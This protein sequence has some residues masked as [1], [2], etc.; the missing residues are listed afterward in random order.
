MKG[1][2]GTLDR[3]VLTRMASI[4]G[5]CVASFILLFLVVDGFSRMDEFIAS[6][7]A[8]E[9]QGTSV[10]SVVLRFY[11]TKTPRI[12]SYVGPYLT[13]FAGIATILSLART[14]ELVPMISAG[15][16]VHRILLPVYVFAIAAAGMLVYLEERVVPAAIRENDRLDRMVRDQ[17]KV[18]L[19]KIP[20]LTD[21]ETGLRFSVGRWYPREAR[22]TTVLC[23]RYI[24]PAGRLPPGA[25]DVAEL[26]YRR[27]PKTKKVGWYPVGGKLLPAE[28]GP[29]GQVLPA[30]R[31]A[32]DVPIAFGF[33]TEEID[34]F[35]STGEEGIDRAKLVELQRRYPRQ[36]KWAM[37]LQARTARPIASFVL[38]LIGIP[39]VASPEKRSITWGLGLALGVCMAYFGAD[40]LFRE[41]GARGALNAVAAVWIPPVLFTSAALSLMDRV[42]T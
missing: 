14:N 35:A 16:S 38:F 25:L 23:Q 3:Y 12:V 13:L 8:I 6:A 40:F 21:P 26:V 10:W 15:R 5:I 20:H 31:L 17:G 41:L 32:P 36:H 1:A 29:E 19:S 42:V 4:Y 37:D 18:E 28:L 34:V 24:D 2:F 30:I 33:T 11:A 22:L 9:A 7:K 27:N 39:F